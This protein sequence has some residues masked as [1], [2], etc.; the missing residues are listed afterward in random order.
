MTRQKSLDFVKIYLSLLFFGA[1]SLYVS[2]LGVLWL[3]EH[4]SYVRFAFKV[5]VGLYLGCIVCLAPLLFPY[6]FSFFLKLLRIKEIAPRRYSEILNS[7]LRF[8]IWDELI[9]GNGNNA[10]GT[11]S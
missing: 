8:I 7:P 6:F 11:S 9:S 2:G 3:T 1:I 4:N 5:V 10:K